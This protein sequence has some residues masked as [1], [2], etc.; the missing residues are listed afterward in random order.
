MFY[1]GDSGLSGK[2]SG[3]R[4][5]YPPK[6]PDIH[7][8]GS[9]DCRRTGNGYDAADSRMGYVSEDRQETLNRS[10]ESM[11]ELVKKAEREGIIL[12][13]EHLSPISSNIVNTAADLKY[14][15]DTIKSPNLK[16][17]FD[18]CQVHLVNERVKD[19]FEMLGEQI[20]HVHIVDGTP[21]G[22]LAFGD[23]TLDFFFMGDRLIYQKDRKNN[24]Q[25]QLRK[26]GCL[27]FFLFYTLHLVF[28]FFFDGWLLLFNGRWIGLFLL[29]SKLAAIIYY[30]MEL[31]KKTFT[32]A[33]PGNSLNVL[34]AIGMCILLIID[35]FALQL[36]GSI[37]TIIEILEF[38][39]LACILFSPSQNGQ[40]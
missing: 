7:E 37:N 8:K 10:L 13:L 9:R 6:K 20:V 19:Y 14:V 18:T 1:P 16:A 17:M 27:W 28:S 39:L 35:I 30:G 5:I 36:T 34:C 31:N 25:P 22:H 15:L 12:A 40:S 21:G 11:E 24:T 4:S 38:V 23:G 3:L 33:L 26:Y 29:L 32:R 2:Y